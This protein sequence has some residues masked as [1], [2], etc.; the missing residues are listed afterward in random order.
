VDFREVV[1]VGSSS[2]LVHE[3]GEVITELVGE[4]LLGFV[5]F[6]LESVL[7]IVVEGGL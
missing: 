7:G 5:S 4:G 2:H 6:K 3:G 1:V